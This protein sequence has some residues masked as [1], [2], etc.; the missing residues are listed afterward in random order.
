MEYPKLQNLSLE[1]VTPEEVGAS[2]AEQ[3]TLSEP[4]KVENK[5]H[6]E[7]PVTEVE[8]QLARIRDIAAQVE[9]LQGEVASF[10]GEVGS[11]RYVF[12]EESLMSQLLALDST[13]T[14][15]LQQIRSARKT[16]TTHIQNLLSQLEALAVS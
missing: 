15:G 12:L 3:E 6:V 4:T 5:S 10:S 2:T 8:A 16:V 14:F 13:Q 1:E 7:V 9:A 11:K